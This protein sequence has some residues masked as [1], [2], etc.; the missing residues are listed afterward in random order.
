[1]AEPQDT[2]V[3][4]TNVKDVSK[5]GL[6]GSALL[7]TLEEI[8][9][10]GFP[11]GLVRRLEARYGRRGTLADD[12]VGD[13]LEAMVRYSD[14]IE[15]RDPQAYLTAAASHALRKA[16]KRAQDHEE[17]DLE[18]APDEGLFRSE[19]EGKRLYRIAE[20]LIEDWEN[21]NMRVVTLLVIQATFLGEVLTTSELRDEAQAI[22][23]E[24]ISLDSVRKLKERGLKRLAAAFAERGLR[25]E[26]T[27]DHD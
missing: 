25:P 3:G 8:V 23:S 13:A 6:S 14:T 27:D 9:R 12:A 18:D 2:A 16:L 10:K 26:R 1:V 11:E 7:R 24:E 4:G 19:E 5:K 22:L 15:A 21:K 17:V 20:G